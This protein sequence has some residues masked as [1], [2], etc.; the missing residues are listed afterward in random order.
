MKEPARPDESTIL[1]FEMYEREAALCYR[2]QIRRPENWESL[3]CRLTRHEPALGCIDTDGLEQR[4][5]D[6][7]DM[8]DV[9]VCIGDESPARKLSL[10]CF[11]AHLVHPDSLYP[12]GA[13]DDDEDDDT[14]KHTSQMMD[15]QA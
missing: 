12:W 13:S 5:T 10:A 6:S 1:G 8:A 2:I 9:A 14:E 11:L 7:R 3:L 15:H 4:R